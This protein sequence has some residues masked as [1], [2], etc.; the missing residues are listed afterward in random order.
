MGCFDGLVVFICSSGEDL[1]VIL[2]GWSEW[3][4]SFAY[5]G[6]SFRSYGIVRVWVMKMLFLVVGDVL[7]D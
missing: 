2:G 1:L 5:C 6:L 3:F 4:W 7:G